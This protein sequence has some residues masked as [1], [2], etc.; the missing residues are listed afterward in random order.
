ML[1]QWRSITPVDFEDYRMADECDLGDV[2]FQVS[3]QLGGIEF[4]I[5][6]H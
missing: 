5:L 6:K 1:T 2:L 3:W 4:E